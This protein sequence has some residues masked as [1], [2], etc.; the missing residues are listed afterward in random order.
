MSTKK[1]AIAGCLAV[2]FLFCMGG[3]AMA[4]PV[5]IQGHW[6]ET[7]ILDW[8][9]KGLIS[10]YPDSTI[11]PNSE[12]TRAEFMAITNR[13]FGFTKNSTKTFND[14]SPSDWYAGEIAKAIAQGY[15]K[16]YEDGS[17]KPNQPLTRQEAA[18][19]IGRILK[20]KPLPGMIFNFSDSSSIADWSKDSVAAIVKEG[21]M[22]GY[23]DNTMKPDK[24]ITRAEIITVLARVAGTMVNT[25]E[26]TFGPASGT[27]SLNGNVTVTK[28]GI[29]L[30]NLEIKGNLYL[31]EGIGEGQVTLENVQ[32]K[33]T[34]T[35]S[36]GGINSIVI[37]N[38]T[39]GTVII[40]VPDNAKVRLVTQG[41]TSIDQVE[42]QTNAML[43]GDFIDVLVSAGVIVQLQGSFDKVDI[44]AGANIN[45][46]GGS[47]KELKV[48]EQGNGAQISV[49]AASKIDK[50][51]CDAAATV[52]GTGTITNAEI[53]SNGVSIEQKPAAINIKENIT[54]NINNTTYSGSGEDS[55]GGGG[56]GGAGGGTT[57]P[58]INSASVTLG[59]IVYNATI[60]NY[61][62]GLLDLT[63]ADPHLK[64][65]EGT[66]NVSEDATLSINIPEELEPLLTL[67]NISSTQSLQQGNNRLNIADYLSLVTLDDLKQLLGA[68]TLDLTG[69]LTN[70]SNVTAN[71]SLEIKLP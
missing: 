15:I 24:Q 13:A 8:F 57:T 40:N 55:I 10:G 61:T 51:V 28:P 47:V 21:Y 7:Q 34:T 32:V 52:T 66:I 39:L 59:G 58:K 17:V 43:E 60:S 6:A 41:T 30:R 25:P 63:N 71:V 42:T 38:S 20:L 54:A 56:T 3:M 70:S 50:L 12:V 29:T 64:I 44:Q 9:E 22:G 33:G 18:V 11:K 65:T 35:V 16:G 1:I 53:N 2:L 27:D 19:M 37:I 69:T 31:T 67:L 45:L 4:G 48:S 23:P 14:V 5:D 46:T 26:A 62:Q 68:D 49:D 36:G